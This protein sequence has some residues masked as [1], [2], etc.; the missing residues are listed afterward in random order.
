MGAIEPLSVFRERAS[1]GHLQRRV[2][3]LEEENAVLKVDITQLKALTI[4]LK[5]KEDQIVAEF[6]KKLGKQSI[7][8][9]ILGTK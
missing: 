9:T 1:C 5:E 6:L 7:Q 8:A 3:L 4:V 2:R